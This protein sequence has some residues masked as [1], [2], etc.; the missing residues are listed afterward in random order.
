[1]NHEEL[2]Q[3]TIDQFVVASHHDLP[4]VQHDLA[5][6]PGLLNESASWMETP[7]QAAS[8]VGNRPIAEFLLGQGAP[9]DICAAAMLGMKDEVAAFLDDNR[10]LINA[11]GAHEIPLMF[12]AAIGGNQALVEMLI[13]RGA[14]VNAGAGYE[15]NTALHGAAGFGFPDLVRYLLNQGADFTAKDHEGRTPLDVAEQ[16][17]H[18]DIAALLRDY[19]ENA[20]LTGE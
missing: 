10:D 20:P 19:M 3:E 8:H 13:A 2:T 5:R 7:I 12:H 14:D 15:K 17:G 9:L 18:Q 11:T 4:K 16:T 6:L 1:M